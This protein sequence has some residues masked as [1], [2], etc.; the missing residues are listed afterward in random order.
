MKPALSLLCAGVLLSACSP[1][2][3]APNTLNVPMIRSKGEGVISGHIGDHDSLNAQAAY[4]PA[5]NWGVIADGF[6]ASEMGA[7]GGGRGHL[8]SGGAGYY[9][10]LNPHFM[11]DTYGIVGFGGMENH[12]GQR[13][14]SSSFI[15]YGVQ[16]SVGF[17][18]R[19]FDAFFAS[20]LAALRYFHTNGSDAV[21]VQYLKDAGTQ[22]L[23]EPA[24]TLRAGFDV[25]KLQL[26]LG[27]SVNLTDRQFKQEVSIASLG[28]VY[29]FGRK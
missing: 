22:F 16:P 4:S 18:S 11:W 21:E 26:Q 9:R 12:F 24:V 13:N 6:W 2:Y 29:T 25:L 5:E 1:I 7:N 27:H 14:V 3:Y 17:Q 8:I 10:P 15:R 19:Y 23:F 28:V 20:R